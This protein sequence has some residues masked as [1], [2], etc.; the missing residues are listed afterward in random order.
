MSSSKGQPSSRSPVLGKVIIQLNDERS[1][2][3]HS[4]KVSPVT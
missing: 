2:T 4:G 1:S 3:P